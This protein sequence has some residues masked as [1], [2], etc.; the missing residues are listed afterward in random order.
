MHSCPKFEEHLNHL[1]ITGLDKNGNY[2]APKEDIGMF[3][4]GHNTWF[5]SWRG[6]YSKAEVPNGKPFTSYYF[7]YHDGYDDSHYVSDEI[8]YCPWCGAKL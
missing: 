2:A 4:A 5:A 1:I 7:G 3:G 8:Q 6:S